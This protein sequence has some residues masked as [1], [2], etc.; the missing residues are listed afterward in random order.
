MTPEA[1]LEQY[2]KAAEMIARRRSWRTRASAVDLDDLTQDA[3]VGLIEGARKIDDSRHEKQITDYLFT[4]MRYA[5]DKGERRMTHGK[6]RPVYVS[7]PALE[8]DEGDEG[9][10]IEDRLQDPTPLPSVYVEVYDAHRKAADFSRLTAEQERL[11]RLISL[12]DMTC[13][14]AARKMG[15]NPSRAQWMVQ[16]MRDAGVKVYSRQY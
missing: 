13:K 6:T 12:D 14:D 10:W 11:A 16:C 9:D 2:Q 8:N 4:S 7:K 3:F 1:A 15:I 5:V